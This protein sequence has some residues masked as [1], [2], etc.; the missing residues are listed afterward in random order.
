MEAQP[1]TEKMEV[2][3]DVKTNMLELEVKEDVPAPSLVEPTG[4]VPV[5]N[6]ETRKFETLTLKL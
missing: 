4:D 6:R 2:E 1:E 5:S 3:L